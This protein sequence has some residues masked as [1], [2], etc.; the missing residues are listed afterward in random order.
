MTFKLT[1]AKWPLKFY[2]ASLYLISIGTCLPSAFAQSQASAYE[3]YLLYVNQIS[4]F[5]VSLWTG[6]VLFAPKS[7][8]NIEIIYMYP[9]DAVEESDKR[10]IE[11]WFI[12]KIDNDRQLLIGKPPSQNNSN[13]AEHLSYLS[14][15]GLNKIVT[16]S[17]IPDLSDSNSEKVFWTS[18]LRWKSAIDW[19]THKQ[20][21]WGEKSPKA[22]SNLH[23]ETA[24]LQVPDTSL[25]RHDRD[26]QSK[27]TD[28][29]S[30]CLITEAARVV[31]GE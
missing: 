11:N 3:T 15:S 13:W 5:Y 26:S 27:K 17:P 29:P 21:V 23:S 18:K 24:S 25:S 2:T 20:K 16:D 30:P 10:N 22:E 7:L 12:G 31:V 9:M 8:E 6:A 1:C 14:E 28:S 4:T 19:A